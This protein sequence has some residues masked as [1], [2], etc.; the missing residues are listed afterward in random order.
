MEVVISAA[1]QNFALCFLPLPALEPSSHALQHVCQTHNHMLSGHILLTKSSLSD[2]HDCGGKDSCKDS[3]V[4]C[5]SY[6][7]GREDNPPLPCTPGLRN[8]SHS[9]GLLPQCRAQIMAM[10]WVPWQL[11]SRQDLFPCLSGAL[12][13]IC[14]VCLIYH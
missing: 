13:L 10:S 8:S 1:L 14:N 9:E 2:S 4:S 11:S 12:V 5:T 7:G 3:G 6:P